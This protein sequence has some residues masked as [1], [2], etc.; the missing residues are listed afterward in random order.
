MASKQSF[1]AGLVCFPLECP[2]IIFGS[3]IETK[4]T[5]HEKVMLMECV[6][7]SFINIDIHMAV[8]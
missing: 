3:S 1:L 8:I 4:K 5:Y 6:G 2:I 7:I